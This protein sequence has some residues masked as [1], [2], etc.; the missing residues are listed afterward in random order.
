MTHSLKMFPHSERSLCSTPNTTVWKFKQDFR[1]ADSQ[2][3][4]PHTTSY[5]PVN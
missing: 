1:P 4:T 3:V 5:K 2:W